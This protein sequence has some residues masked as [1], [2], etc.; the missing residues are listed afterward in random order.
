MAIT[1]DDQ[2]KWNKPNGKTKRTKTNKTKKPSRKSLIRR[3]DNT[4]KL[5]IKEKYKWRCVTCGR[6]QGDVTMSWGHLKTSGSYITRWNEYNLACQCI[7]CN[8]KHEYDDYPYNAWF[9]KTYGISKWHELNFMFNHSR[10]IKDWE[11]IMIAEY[12]EKKLKCL[13]TDKKVSIPEEIKLL[14]TL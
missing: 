12:Y 5:Y 7:P 11:I 8:G 9:I 1:K 2:L 6:E 3:A 4:C 10:P 14:V 13:G